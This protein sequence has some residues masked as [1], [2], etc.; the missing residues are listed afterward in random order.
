MW[1][2]KICECM[3][4]RARAQPY[5]IRFYIYQNRAR[6]KKRQQHGEQQQKQQQSKHSPKPLNHRD[7]E[8]IV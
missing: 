7:T 5:T 3:Q 2:H 6:G 8:Q 1:L 4:G